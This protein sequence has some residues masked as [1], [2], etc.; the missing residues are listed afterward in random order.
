M[1][2]RFRSIDNYQAIEKCLDAS[3]WLEAVDE[4]GG[5]VLKKAWK[6]IVFRMTIWEAQ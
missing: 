6:K 5:G 3:R 1:R 4:F 2:G